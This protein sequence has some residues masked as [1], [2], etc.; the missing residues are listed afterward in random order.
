MRPAR[1]GGH[2]TMLRTLDVRTLAIAGGSMVRLAREATAG[3]ALRGVGPRS[4]HIAGFGY[5]CF[6]KPDDLAGAVLVFVRPAPE[7]AGDYVALRCANGA[8]VALTPTC[9]AN[10]LGYVPPGDFAHGD[11][12]SARLGFALAGA[13][14]GC[15]PEGLARAVLERATETLRGTLDELIAD[16]DLERAG[17]ELIGGGG[18]AAALV[19]FAAERLGFR[20]RLARDAA[21]IAPLGVALALVRDVVERTVVAPTPQDVI[22]VRRMA[23]ERVV[24][25]GAAPELVEVTIE[26]DARRNLIRATASGATAAAAGEASR[27]IAT[28]AQRA[29]AAA[30]ALRSS[31]T[32]PAFTCGEFAIYTA[33]R[34]ETPDACVV[35][36]RGV[37]RATL[38][39][40]VLRLTTVAR[41]ER[42][43][44]R[45]LEDASAF[46]DVGRALP[47][48]RLAYGARVADL[49]TLA[50]VA[51]VTALASEE[52]RGLDP[53][54]PVAL[55]AEMR[56]A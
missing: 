45:L 53:A 56:D 10:L 12:E 32:Q 35:D 5:A 51:Q 1:V 29:A 8:H 3:A 46:G 54:T 18:G 40:V 7:D 38:Q 26:I 4:A 27:E 55:L 13:H 30:R 52:L 50:E 42:D 34:R 14:L 22:A 39:R 33:G 16:Y 36:G 48:V 23:F 24:K 20:F 37:V 31:E 28:D 9:A 6:T 2:R 15:A 44:A 19:P 41:V 49:G 21:M 11:A 25:A 47:G 17:V 43:L